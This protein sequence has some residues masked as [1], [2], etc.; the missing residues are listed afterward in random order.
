MTSFR[1]PIEPLLLR[2]A[3]E[4]VFLTPADAAKRVGVREEIL[5]DWESGNGGP[6][7]PQLRHL[8]H[9]YRQPL[10]AFLLA[11]PPR[12]APALVAFRTLPQTEHMS[13]SREFVLAFRRA[14][15]QQAT[16]RYLAEL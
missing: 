14:I 12:E 1:P 6:T 8:G 11:T 3:R 13:P 2:W 7:L 4:G 16:A 10:A 15:D 9:I 5:A